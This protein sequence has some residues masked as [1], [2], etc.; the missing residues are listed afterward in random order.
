M[1]PFFPGRKRVRHGARN[2]VIA[3]INAVLLAFVF[4]GLVVWTTGIVREKELGLL[5]VLGLRDYLLLVIVSILVL[6]C[7]V[8]WW[9]RINHRL[10]FLWRFHRVHH[11]DPFMDVTT[12]ARFHFG[13]IIFSSLIRLVLIL[14]VGIPLDAI[15]LYDMIQLP[16]IAFHHA[17]IALPPKAD[18]FVRLFVVTPFMHKVHH[19]RQQLETDSN[20]SSI[21]SIWDRVFGSYR[22]RGEYS[23]IQFGL[24]GYDSDVTQSVPGILQTPLLPPDDRGTA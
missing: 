18:R 13:E 1:F 22:E 7:W 11:S 4:A 8:Y 12:A 5:V 16:V 6:D 3:G 21:L 20:Y 2:L 23:T 15:I 17:N 24:S 19:S 9:H 14:L 10:P